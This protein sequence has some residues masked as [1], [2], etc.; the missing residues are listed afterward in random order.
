M[1]NGIIT[2][3]ISN[4]DEKCCFCGNIL[5]ISWHELWG[6]GELIDGMT[7]KECNNCCVLPLPPPLAAPDD[8]LPF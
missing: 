3:P 4:S 5:K 1:S 2:I 8:G 6:R 7:T